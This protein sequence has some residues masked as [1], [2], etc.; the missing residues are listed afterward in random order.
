MRS[1]LLLVSLLVSA[2]NPLGD[3]DRVM[4]NY[5]WSLCRKLL[6]NGQ[7]TPLGLEILQTQTEHHCMCI[8]KNCVYVAAQHKQRTSPFYWTYTVHDDNGCSLS[9]QEVTGIIHWNHIPTLVC[10]FQSA[11]V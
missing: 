6:L 11:L 10:L 4:E 7:M 1:W 8:W 2:L 9:H 3:G 5:S